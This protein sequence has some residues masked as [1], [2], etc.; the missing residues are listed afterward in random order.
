MNDSAK[1]PMGT[2]NPNV[3]SKS[4]GFAL[5]F[6]V[7]KSIKETRIAAAIKAFLDA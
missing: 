6:Q 7:A 1:R 5:E 3:L 4:V 2:H